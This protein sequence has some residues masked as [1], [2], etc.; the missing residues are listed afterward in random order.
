[1][2]I[3]K[4]LP[5][6]FSSFGTSK[7]F[8]SFY[9]PVLE[10]QKHVPDHD[11]RQQGGDEGD[12]GEKP[13]ARGGQGVQINLMWNLIDWRVLH[14]HLHYNQTVLADYMHSFSYQLR[15]SQTHELSW[16][17]Q[18]HHLKLTWNVFGSIGALCCWS[19]L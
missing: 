17:D 3:Q 10:H 5:D 18:S 11:V 7:I 2:E 14:H 6:L 8:A 13:D 9:F 12:E 16:T 1:M 19:V 15:S 4:H